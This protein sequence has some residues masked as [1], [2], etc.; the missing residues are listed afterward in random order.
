MTKYGDHL[1]LAI[2]GIINASNG[3]MKPLTLLGKC[4]RLEDFLRE[5]NAYEASCVGDWI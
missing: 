5:A 2:I 4:Q 3:R 1:V